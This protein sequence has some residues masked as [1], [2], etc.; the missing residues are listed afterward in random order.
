MSGASA[1]PVSAR[2]QSQARP[3]A[4]WRRT[5][6]ACLGVRGTGGFGPAI[7]VGLALALCVA[8]GLAAHHGNPTG[9]IR[10]GSRWAAAFQPPPHAVLVPGTGYDGQ[11]FWALARDPLVLQAR[12]LGVFQ[13]QGFRLQ[14]VA[15]PVLADLLAGG[16]QG[17][18]PWTLLAV[19]VLAILGITVAFSQYAIR[20]GWSGWWG[21]AVGLLPGFAYALLGDLSDALAVAAMLGGLLAWRRDR[22]WLAAGLLSVAVLAR[23]PMALAV[24]ALAVTGAARAGRGRGRAAR[25]KRELFPLVVL[26]TLVFIGWQ[27]YI[28]ARLGASTSAPGSA[29]T[30]PFGGIAAELRHAL[31]AGSTVDAIWDVCYLVLMCAGI[32][33]AI[34]LVRRRASAPAVAALLFALTLPF[35]SFG[36][37]WS[38]TRLSAPMFACLLLTGLERRSRAAL[39]ICVA[40]AALG[41]LVPFGVG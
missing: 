36:G 18:L 35:L 31:A 41:V 13:F 17:A 9:F 10:F 20:R 19:N 24:L 34:E 11:Y 30:A 16:R 2:S 32:A 4:P 6:S 23:E 28:R 21:L 39:A 7:V 15:Y 40:V 1:P 37:A 38:Y 27:L 22:R 12:T 5:L 33:V 8:S 26:P 14:R 29:F 3:A 25:L